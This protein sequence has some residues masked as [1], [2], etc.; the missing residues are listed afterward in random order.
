MNIILYHLDELLNFHKNYEKYW[1]PSIPDEDGNPIY[2]TKEAE[3]HM[4][5]YSSEIKKIAIKFSK[6]EKHWT[7]YI[8]DLY[9]VLKKDGYIIDNKIRYAI[10]PQGK[11]FKGYVH[12]ARM[13]I[14]WNVLKI[15]GAITALYGIVNMLKSVL[16]SCT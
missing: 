16:L 13:K 3:Y 6:D 12:K 7:K 2:P 4:K 11:M 10:T 15:L 14:F 9:G 1:C 5:V 8:S